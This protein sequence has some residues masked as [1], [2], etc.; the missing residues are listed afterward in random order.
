[1]YVLQFLYE[2]FHGSGIICQ[3]EVLVGNV[4]A[5]SVL[6]GKHLRLER[7]VVFLESLFAPI[8]CLQC[9]FLGFKA[10]EKDIVVAR[11]CFP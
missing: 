7:K 10:C 11:W 4:F 2:L 9:S 5:M 3:F 1:V 8:R 6:H